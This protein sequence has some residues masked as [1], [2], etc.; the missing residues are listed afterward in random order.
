MRVW[1]NSHGQ[2]QEFNKESDF[3]NNKCVYV[4]IMHDVHNIYRHTCVCIYIYMRENEQM[5][6]NW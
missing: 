3:L 4:H 2:I 5:E 1:Y 6:L